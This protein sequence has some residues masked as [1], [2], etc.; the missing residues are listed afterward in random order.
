MHETVARLGVKYRPGLGEIR[1]LICR[2]SIRRH[3][4]TAFDAMRLTVV[5]SNDAVALPVAGS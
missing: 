2:T 4:L 3:T 5:A 1:R